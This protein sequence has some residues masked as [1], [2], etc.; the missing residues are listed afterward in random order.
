[1]RANGNENLIYSRAG[2]TESGVGIVEKWFVKIIMWSGV[3]LWT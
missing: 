2:L 1:M 3:A